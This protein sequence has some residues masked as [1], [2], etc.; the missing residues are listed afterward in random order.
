M[1]FRPESNT[2]EAEMDLFTWIMIL[3]AVAALAGLVWRY[4]ADIT[5]WFDRRTGA[6]PFRMAVCGLAALACF[7]VVAFVSPVQLPVAVYK[8]ALVLLAGYLGYWLDVW[9]SPYSRPDGY[10]ARN[11]RTEPG[12]KHDEP[13]H[14]IVPGYET[15]FAAALLRRAL[16]VGCCM[17]AVGLGL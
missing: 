11:W 7:G 13:D 2:L 5:T 17:L 15:V 10:L 16:I 8:L 14:A 6:S 4:R 9:L 1:R 12:F 3:A